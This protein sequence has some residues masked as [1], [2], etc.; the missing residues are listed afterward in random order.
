MFP[1]H[2]LGNNNTVNIV[3]GDHGL[4]AAPTR[5]IYVGSEDPKDP[6]RLVDG[7]KCLRD[8]GYIV[9]SYCWGLTPKDAAWRLTTTSMN[10]FATELSLDILPQTLHD[11]ILWTRKLGEKY[12]WIDSMC[13]QQDDNEDWQIEASK[14]ASI[15]GSAT[16]TIVSASSSAYGGI[17]DRR[18]PLRNSAAELC[19]QNEKEG[20]EEEDSSQFT[21]YILPNGQP[22]NGPPPSP[23]DSR[24]WCYQEN[25]LS[26]RLVKMTQKNCAFQCLGEGSGSGPRM[27]G[28]EQLAKHPEFRWYTLWYRLIER[29][30]NMSISFP[31]DRLPAFYGIG[32]DK[33]GSAYQAGLIQT[34][35]WASL[36]WCRDENQ[37]RLRPGG[38]FKDYIAPSWSWAGIDTPVLFYEANAR[39]WRKPQ[40]EPSIREPELH[41]IEVKALS[42]I[43]FGAVKGGS[44]DLSAHVII[45]RTASVEPF[46]FNTRQGNHTYGRRN[47]VDLL[48]GKALGLIVFDVATEAKD[49]MFICCILLHTADMSLWLKNGTAG[50]GLALSVQKASAE[51]FTCKRVGYVQFTSAFGDVCHRRYITLL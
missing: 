1:F 39:H 36:L 14:M 22:R 28:L 17:S 31:K 29:Y 13:I 27:Q 26:S 32:Y 23:T 24:A 35:P 42:S 4:V 41:H 51:H 45:A 50:L 46:L 30:S 49:D 21:V 20:E 6:A 44:I 2:P 9:L 8:G 25:L 12:I 43:E 19:L 40:L 10:T 47:C 11:A 16:M 18:N 38:R 48:T 3:F 7:Q 33:V 5:L 37:I 34:D 15:Y